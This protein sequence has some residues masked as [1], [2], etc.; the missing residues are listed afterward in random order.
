MSTCRLIRHIN[1]LW[2]FHLWAASQQGGIAR[3]LIFPLCPL[4]EKIQLDVQPASSD[5]PGEKEKERREFIT[6]NANER[7]PVYNSLS[8]PALMAQSRSG[9]S[10]CIQYVY[11]AAMYADP[12]CYS[13]LQ[14]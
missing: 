12:T 14:R 7:V 4:S 2:P 5:G 3:Q 1:N 10:A 6:V 13:T 9:E 8:L 11:V